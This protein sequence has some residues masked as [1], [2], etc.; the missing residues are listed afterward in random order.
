MIAGM[1][2]DKDR[3]DGSLVNSVSSSLV[4]KFDRSREIV[5]YHELV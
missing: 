1:A 5:E 3:I 2:A 4:T